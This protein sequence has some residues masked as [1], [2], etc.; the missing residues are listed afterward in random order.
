[1]S[2]VNYP[3]DEV[4]KNDNGNMGQNGYNLNPNYGSNLNLNVNNEMATV[5]IHTSVTN[6]DDENGDM[7]V[8]RSVQAS[9][10]VVWDFVCNFFSVDGVEETVLHNF[11][12][13]F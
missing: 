6:E 4:N 7:G 12:V 5:I 3:I 9:S 13:F 10:F 8:T 11:F 2:R 1:M